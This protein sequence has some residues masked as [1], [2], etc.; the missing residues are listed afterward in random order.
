MR[1]TNTDTENATRGLHALTMPR[2]ASARGR[3]CCLHRSRE[4]EKESQLAC[5]ERTLTALVGSLTGAV[6][7]AVE[8]TRVRVSGESIERAET[9][10]TFGRRAPGKSASC[11]VFFKT[12]FARQ[13]ISSETR[14]RGSDESDPVCG[15]SSYTAL[16]FREYPPVASWFGKERPRSDVITTCLE[17]TYVHMDTAQKQLLPVMSA[18]LAIVTHSFLV[19]SYCSTELSRFWPS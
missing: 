12:K 18:M 15:H 7:R 2:C 4:R 11:F 5:T 17:C 3:E 10:R 13:V 6:S 16:R 9:V 8:S 1:R 14:G 19:G